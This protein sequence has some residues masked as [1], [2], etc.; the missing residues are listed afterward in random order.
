MEMTAGWPTMI[1]KGKFEVDGLIEHIFSSYDLDN[2]PS[3]VDGCNIFDDVSVVMKQFHSM[4]Y[5]KFDSYLLETTGKRISEYDTHEM[6]G[7]ITIIASH[8]NP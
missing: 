8:S 1:G 7:W 2:P 6:K 5:E 3:E 4:A